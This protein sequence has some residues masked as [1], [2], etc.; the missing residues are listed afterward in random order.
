MP[1]KG[2]AATA[3]DAVQDSDGNRWSTSRWRDGE[4]TTVTPGR[5]R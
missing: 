4:I 1:K 3:R 2:R 5:E